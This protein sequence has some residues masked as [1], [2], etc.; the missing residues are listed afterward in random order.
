MFS[1]RRG[2]QLAV[3]VFTITL[4]GCATYYQK[5]L[6]FQEFFE[7]G[8]IEQAA[9]IL[10]QNRRAATGKDRLLFFLHKGVVLQMLGNY[11]ESNEFLEEAY[12]YIEDLQRN[13][14]TE[15]LSFLTNPTI[16]PYRGEDFEQVQLHYYKALNYLRL[17]QFEEALVECR[18]MNIKLNSLNDKYANHKNRYKR[19]AFAYNLMGIIFEA[20]GE[21]NNAFVSYR[22]AYEAYK[23][24]YREHFHVDVPEQLK[25]DL[26][27]TAYLNGFTEELEQYEK[28]F[29]MKYIHQ[30]TE[31]GEL[32][33]FW[34]NGLGPVKSEW[35][36]NF[37]IVKGSGGVITF[38]NEEQGLSFP[39][40][41]EGRSRDDALKLGDLKAVRVAFPKYLERRPYFRS[42]ALSIG[43]EDY[44]LE[45]TQNIN[46]IA[47]KT[48]EDRMIRELGNSLL[49][50]ALKQVS[51]ELVRKKSKGLGALLS[52]AHA[53][54][55][56]A[57]TRNWQTLPYSI[58]YARIPLTQGE[59]TVTLKTRTLHGRNETAATFQFYLERNETVFHTYHS[60]E[61]LPPQDT[62]R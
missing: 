43:D 26:L 3:V 57:D 62:F 6:R 12:L 47:F 51:E 10:D 27:R 33:F 54:T 58:H 30:P 40:S 2:I 46:E 55:E 28:E 50:L 19:D 52:A 11:R 36:I 56:K 61:S 5:N 24:D 1:N 23:E 8:E 38:V 49:R 20:A 35:S 29:N 14:A 41:V 25:R 7:K 60:L 4:A 42:A 17:N 22:N 32:V 31:G 45:I 59:N 18:R 13:Y 16:L 44:P 21:V 34:N 48:L 39:F 15:A 53:L 9:T 37:F